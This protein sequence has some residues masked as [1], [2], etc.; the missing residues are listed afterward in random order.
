MLTGQLGPYQ[1]VK[2][3]AVGEWPKSIAPSFPTPSR[4]GKLPSKSF[5]RTTA[6]I[7][8]SSACCSTKRDSRWLKHPNIVT[9]TIWGKDKEQYYLVMELVEGVDLFRLEQRAT[10][11]RLSIPVP[12][13]AYIARELARGLH[14]AHELADP[15]G[16]PLHVVHRDVSR[17]ECASVP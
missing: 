14:F 13:C 4:Y 2:K 8:T 17:A 6:K 11:L 9:T 1:L 5:T 3:I 15:A 10:D 16:K 12:L 7:P